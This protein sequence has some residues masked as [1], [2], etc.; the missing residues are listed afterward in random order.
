M[1]LIL[2]ASDALEDK[3]G[4]ISISTGVM[5]ARSDYL[6]SCGLDAGMVERQYV[7]FEVSAQLV[8]PNGERQPV[9]FSTSVDESS[10]VRVS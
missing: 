7:Y 6:G 1:N 9:R 8:H 2:N 4:R 5:T 3:P 10:N